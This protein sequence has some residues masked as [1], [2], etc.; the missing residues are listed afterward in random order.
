M[1]SKRSSIYHI[2][3]YMKY[4]QKMEQDIS[5]FSDMQVLVQLSISTS[6]FGMFYY[7]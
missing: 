3:I 5:P 1:H 7:S 6:N 2:G 4:N